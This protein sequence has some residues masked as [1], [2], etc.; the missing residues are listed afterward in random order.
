MTDTTQLRKELQ[1]FFQVV[2][3]GVTSYLSI[4][5]VPISL[6]CTLHLLH[7]NILNQLNMDNLAQSTMMPNAAS[8]VMEA[9]LGQSFFS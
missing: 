5:V 3:Q 6:I 9:L 8:Q 2:F 7:T 4:I 1:W